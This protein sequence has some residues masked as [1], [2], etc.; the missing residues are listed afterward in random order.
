MYNKR[1]E[2]ESLAMTSKG[3]PQIG[4]PT[5]DLDLI[6]GSPQGKNCCF[7][8][9][10]LSVAMIASYL[11]FIFLTGISLQQINTDLNHLGADRHQEIR[12]SGYILL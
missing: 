9:F 5:R 6:R 11:S 10:L 8:Y 7:L 3:L 2:R 12:P 4:G 1:G